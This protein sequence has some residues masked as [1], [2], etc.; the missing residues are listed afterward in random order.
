LIRYRVSHYAAVIFGDALFNSSIVKIID[1]KDEDRLKA[2][3]T[4]KKYKD[5]ELLRSA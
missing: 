1:V 3:E 4:F 5:K 2:W